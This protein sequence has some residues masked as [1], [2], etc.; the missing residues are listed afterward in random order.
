MTSLIFVKWGFEHYLYLRGEVVVS[1]ICVWIII[2]QKNLKKELKSTHISFFL[3]IAS[4]VD[5]FIQD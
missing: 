1:R 4:K 5:T 3:Y 2:A